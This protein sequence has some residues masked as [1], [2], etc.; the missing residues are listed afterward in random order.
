MA[1]MEKPFMVD[2]DRAASEGALR[3]KCAGAFL[4]RP[5]DAGAFVVSCKDASGVQH[6]VV[7]LSGYYVPS[8][9]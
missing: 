6:V 7:S 1:S 4:L 2:I 8:Q 9:Q 5:K 3:S